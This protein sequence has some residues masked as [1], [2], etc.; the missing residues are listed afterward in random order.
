MVLDK[1]ELSKKTVKDLKKE[2]SDRYLPL[3]P[4]LLTSVASQRV[5]H[6]WSQARAH[7]SAA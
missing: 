7:R 2:L 4:R 6:K 1:E 5:G 3:L